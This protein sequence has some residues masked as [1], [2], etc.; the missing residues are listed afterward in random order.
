MFF[1]LVSAALALISDSSVFVYIV[2]KPF[3]LSFLAQDFASIQLINDWNFL[4]TIWINTSER[5]KWQRFYTFRNN[6]QDA[7]PMYKN[8]EPVCSQVYCSLRSHRAWQLHFMIKDLGLAIKFFLFDEFSFFTSK[9]ANSSDFFH[10]IKILFPSLPFHHQT[11]FETMM[12]WRKESKII[13][14]RKKTDFQREWKTAE[15]SKF[16]KDFW[17]Q[18]Q[19]VELWGFFSSSFL[20]FLKYLWKFNFRFNAHKCIP[21]RQSFFMRRFCT[22]QRQWTSNDLK[23]YRSDKFVSRL[24]RSSQTRVTMSLV[25]IRRFVFSSIFDARVEFDNCSNCFNN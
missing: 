13:W 24:C 1:A 6:L 12:K 22:K 15:C 10:K 5:K 23:S 14:R 3:F 7:R 20:L 9:L 17:H 18:S 4:L 25:V 19:T 21:R 2:R 11:T 8:T 16:L